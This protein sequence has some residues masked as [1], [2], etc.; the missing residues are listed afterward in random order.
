[1]V[2]FNHSFLCHG[3]QTVIG[4]SLLFKLFF[5]GFCFFLI[6]LCFLQ[7]IRPFFLALRLPTFVFLNGLLIIDN[8]IGLFL[9]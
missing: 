7:E 5:E 2:R 4:F 8:L 3:K 1:M 9:E 6:E